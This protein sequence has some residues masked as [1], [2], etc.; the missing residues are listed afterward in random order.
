M[1]ATRR[2]LL[3]SCLTAVPLD[4][5]SSSMVLLLQA[6]TFCLC[7][8]QTHP[9]LNPTHPTLIPT[10]PIYCPKVKHPTLPHLYNPFFLIQLK[11]G[12][13]KHLPD[14]SRYQP[15]LDSSKPPSTHTHTLQSACSA[16]PTPLLPH[17]PHMPPC[18]LSGLQLL[19]WPDFLPPRPLSAFF[20]FF[21]PFGTPTHP[22]ILTLVL[23]LVTV[24]HCALRLH[25]SLHDWQFPYL[26]FPLGLELSW[27]L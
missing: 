17:W 20:A 21:L 24:S 8:F 18:T 12:F 16:S 3:C 10:L 9:P 14:L 6:V 4:L 15:S 2:F 5:P 26:P 22:H 27:D 11:L 23:T 7:H 25:C 13:Q 19:L 1:E